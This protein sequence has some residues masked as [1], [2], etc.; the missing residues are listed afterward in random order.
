MALFSR[1]HD[2]FT[3]LG[4][5]RNPDITSDYRA[6]SY[7]DTSQYSSVAIYYYVILKDWVSRY[8]LDWVT[9]FVQWET[10]CT[11]RHSLIQ[12]DVIAYDAGCSY[13]DTSAMVDSKMMTYLCPWVD[14]YARFRMCHLCQYSWNQR[15]ILDI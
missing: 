13:H 7:R 12:L 5:F 8:A 14:I 4:T 2:I 15:H 10:L 1:L 11:E 6:L 3:R 9:I